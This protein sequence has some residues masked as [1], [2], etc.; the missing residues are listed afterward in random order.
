[1]K[2]DVETGHKHSYKFC[3]NF[4]YKSTITNMVTVRNFEGMSGECNVDRMHT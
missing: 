1:M 2:F 3:M 4:V